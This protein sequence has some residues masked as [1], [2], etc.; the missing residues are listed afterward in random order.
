MIL[1]K[2]HRIVLAF[3]LVL[4]SSWSALHA[5]SGLWFFGFEA[6]SC[7]MHLEDKPGWATVLR[8]GRYTQDRIASFEGCYM[9]GYGDQKFESFELGLDLRAMPDSPFTP[10]VGLGIGTITSEDFT[11][12]MGYLVF[13]FDVK[14]SRANRIRITVQRASHEGRSGPNLITLGIEHR[15]L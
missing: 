10:F 4:F 13:G 3:L 2:G 1:Q 5:E 11:A 7:N 12:S 15:L 6:G 14:V 8:I 9:R